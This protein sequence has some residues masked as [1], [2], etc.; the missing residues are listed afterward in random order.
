MVWIILVAVAVV[1]VA[2]GGLA[3]WSSGRAK[4]MGRRG[5]RDTTRAERNAHYEGQRNQGNWT[6]GT[7]G[8]T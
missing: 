4:P 2:L 6:G 8:I 7:G 3:W 1:V 5:S